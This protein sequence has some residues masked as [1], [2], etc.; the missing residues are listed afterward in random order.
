MSEFEGLTLDRPI[1]PGAAQGRLVP[2][3]LAAAAAAVVGALIW[4]GITALT[5]YQIGFM[6]I[7][8]GVLVGFAVRLAGEG[9]TAVYRVIAAAAAGLGCAFGNLLT[10][11]YVFANEVQVPV[12]RV[13][14]ALDLELI[15][16]IMIGMFSPIDLLFY[17]LAIHQAWRLAVDDGMGGEEEPREVEDQLPD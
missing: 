4:A 12:T 17:A 7:G 16:N 6:A 2:A 14:E 5:N 3:I 9:E 10:G 13:L 1:G 11:A 15:T 8:V